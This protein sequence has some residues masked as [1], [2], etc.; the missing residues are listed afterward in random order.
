MKQKEAGQKK[1]VMLVAPGFNLPT[2]GCLLLLVIHALVL[3][4]GG[5]HET[6]EKLSSLYEWIAL[7]WLGFLEGNAAA[8]V[9]HQFFHG[10]WLHVAINALLFYYTA[11]RL[12]HIL[13]PS[14]ILILFLASGVGAGIVYI[15]SQALFSNLSPNPLVGASGGVMGMFLAQTVIYPDSRMLFLPISGRNMGKGF[16][17]ASL[18]LFMMTP[19]LGIPLFS[20]VGQ[21]MAEGFGPLLFQMG[22]LYHFAAGMIGFFLVGR[23]LPRLVTLEELQ[24]ERNKREKSLH[25]TSQAPSFITREQGG[26]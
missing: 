23:L 2:I 11:A 18:L 4:N 21:W 19:S 7:S 20:E 26:E 12:G 22:H 6:P 17:V 1:G 14:R 15:A 10:D 25:T 16:L 8:L 13:R 24:L 9:T 5:T 3:I